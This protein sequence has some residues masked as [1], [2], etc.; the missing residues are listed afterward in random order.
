MTTPNPTAITTDSGRPRPQS[1]RHASPIQPVPMMKAVTDSSEKS[2]KEASVPDS[3]ST[4]KSPASPANIATTSRIRKSRVPT[5][6][7]KA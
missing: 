7:M 5:A 6:A 2:V 3:M 1:K 4:S